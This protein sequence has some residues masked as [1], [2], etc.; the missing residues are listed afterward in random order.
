[1][2]ERQEH[3]PEAVER[4]VKQ[5]LV[6]YKAVKLYPSA[7]SIPKESA[8]DAI[9]MLRHLLRART[10]V[11]FIVTREGLV[12]DGMPILPGREAFV[13]FALDMYQHGIGEVRLRSGVTERELTEFMAV[14][15]EPLEDVISA[16]G[17]ESRM[18]ER[19]IDSITVVELQTTIVDGEIDTDASAGVA[20]KPLSSEEV[21]RLLALGRGMH[22][23]DRRALVRFAQDPAQLAAYLQS[24]VVAGGDPL[25]GRLASVVEDLARLAR[26]EL[27]E[28]QPVLQRA[29]AEAVMTLDPQTRFDLLSCRLLEDARSDEALADVIRQFDVNEICAAL[30]AGLSDDPVSQEG[31]ARAIRNLAMIDQASRSHV[32]DAARAA[33]ENAGVAGVVTEAV[34]EGASPT[35]LH[36]PDATGPVK[37]DTVADV[38][39]LVDLAPQEER[40]ASDP[41]FKAL[42]DEA[43]RGVSDGDVL[44]TL[45]SVAAFERRPNVFDSILSLVEDDLDMLVGWAEYAEAAHVAAVLVA[46]A[47][48]ESLERPQRARVVE[49]VATLASPASL[50][51][52]SQALRIYGPGSSEY[53][54]CQGFIRS[55]SAYAIDPLLEVLA[56]EQDMAARKALVDLLRDIAPADI[57]L[58]GG[59][60]ADQRWYFVRNVVSILGHTRRSE[61][62]PFLARTLRHSDARVR[63]ET[64]RALSALNDRLAEEILVTALSDCDEQNVRL[65]ARYLG[66]VGSRSATGALIAV[67]RGES[68]GSRDVGARV[69]AVEALGRIGAPE[70]I[71]AL[72]TVAHQRVLLRGGK[73]REVRVAAEAALRVAR[74]TSATEGRRR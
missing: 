52:V 43:V 55:L 72:E 53:L 35:V 44:A 20:D 3:A 30:A 34:L 1:M 37:G 8:E 19:R 6:T 65:A 50:K 24:I 51:L 12:Y 15:A 38:L 22:P 41:A 39:K 29:V 63:R 11:S 60:I 47:D 66:G 62:V 16:G 58:L 69:E 42:H 74:S 28:D 73:A 21:E 48:D 33:L 23:I 57:V 32:L 26:D 4:L 7:S 68:R 2:R 67:A 59:H 9:T 40:A 71:A 5:L 18:W 56:E 61:A 49:A 25:V 46:L 45:V 14:L 13:E 36:M 54:S 64:I 31:L 70:A 17:F 10:D 27:S